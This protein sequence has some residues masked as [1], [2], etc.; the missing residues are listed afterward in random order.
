VLHALNVS[1]VLNIIVV[2][3]VLL[4]VVCMRTRWFPC[5]FMAVIFEGSYM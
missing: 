5:D 1:V 2:E 3:Q 4:F